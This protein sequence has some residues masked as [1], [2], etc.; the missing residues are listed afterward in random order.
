MRQQ[1]FLRLALV[2]FSS[3]DAVGVV[4][5][6]LRKPCENCSRTASWSAQVDGIPAELC[7]WCLLYGGVSDWSK[8]SIDEINAM[9]AFAS[10]EAMRRRGHNTH[11]PELDALGRL[12][13]EDAEKLVMG[14]FF[15]SKSIFGGLR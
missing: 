12:S 11:A 3:E 10:S 9:G 8:K 15:T 2:H 7:G 4:D 14:I 13:R 5:A 6:S 1:P